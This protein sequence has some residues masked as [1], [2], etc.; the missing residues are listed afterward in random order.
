MVAEIYGQRIEAKSMIDLKRK[1]SM[2]ANRYCNSYDVMDVIADG[3]KIHLCRTNKVTPWNTIT[4]G[5][6]I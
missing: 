3:F 2:I 6:W 4:Y 1:A 5:K